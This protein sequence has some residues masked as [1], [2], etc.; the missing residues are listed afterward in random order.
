MFVAALCGMQTGIKVLAHDTRNI[1][2][3]NSDSATNFKILF[4]NYHLNVMFSAM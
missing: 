4:D 3:V 1:I 2:I